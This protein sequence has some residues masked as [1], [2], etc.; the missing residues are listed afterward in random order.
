MASFRI[1]AEKAKGPVYANGS[2]ICWGVKYS[3]TA[4]WREQGD[5]GPG[6]SDNVKPGDWKLVRN[7]IVRAEPE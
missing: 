7:E 2:L 1:R 5:G 6:D 3:I 4:E